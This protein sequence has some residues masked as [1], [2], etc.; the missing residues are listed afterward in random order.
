MRP[1]KDEIDDIKSLML[2]R[3]IAANPSNRIKIPDNIRLRKQSP[4]QQRPVSPTEFINGRDFINDRKNK[5]WSSLRHDMEIIFSGTDNDGNLIYSP[6]CNVYLN[7]SG[8]GSGKSTQ[9]ALFIS[10]MVYWLHCLKNPF[11]YFG[12]YDASTLLLMNVAPVEKKAKDIV[13][14]KVFSMIKNISW[15]RD[16]GYM[17]DKRLTSRLRF[18]RDRYD[19]NDMTREEVEKASPLI[20]IVPAS[21]KPGSAVGEDLFG[22]AIDEACSD[23]GFELLDGT[24]RCEEIFDAMHERR[25]SRFLDQGIIMMISS[26]GSEGRFMERFLT[27]VEEYRQIHDI[28][29][30]VAN[31][32]DMKI[33]HRRRAS[34]EANPKFHDMKTFHYTIERETNEGNILKYEL[35]IPIYFR[36]QMEKN[37]EKT[38]RNICAIPSVSS[39]PYFVEWDRIKDN[40]NKSRQDPMPDNGDDNQL[41]PLCKKCL[42][43]PYEK[44]TACCWELLPKSF[45]G[46]QDIWYMCHVDL[47]TG[48]TK[49]SKRCA[50]GLAISHR[51]PDIDVNGV[52]LPTVVIDLSVRFK[53]SAKKTIIK[54]QSGGSIT[55]VKK[56]EEIDISAV[57]DFIIKLDK[58]RGFKF[59]KIT[60]DGFQCVSEGTLIPT[61][62]G[63]LPIEEVKVG[64]L[65]QSRSGTKPVTKT[66]SFGK[67]PTLILKTQHNDILEGTYKH[68]IEVL[69]K[70]KYKNKKRLPVWEW[71]KIGDIKKGNVIRVWNRNS[72][73]S[74]PPF[75]FKYFDPYEL[76]K[77]SSGRLSKIDSW[78]FPTEMSIELAEWLGVIW[79][80]G[81]IRKDGVEV[82]TS[83]KEVSET[84]LVFEKLFGVPFR[85]KFKAPNTGTVI[86]YS[87]WLIGWMERNNLKKPLIPKAI[88]HSSKETQAAFLRG[89]FSADGSVSKRDGQASF[90]TVHYKLAQQVKIILMSNWGLS[91]TISVV[92]HDDK[93]YLHHDIIKSNYEEHYTLRIR[94]S[95]RKFY[96]IIGFL[97]KEKNDRMIKNI[98]VPGRFIFSKIKSIESGES[99]VYD[100]EIKDDPSYVANGFVSHNSRETL[101]VLLDQGYLAE[102]ASCTKDSY[103]TMRTLWYDSRVNIYQDNWLLS[104]MKKLEERNG[105]VVHAVGASDDLAQAVARVCEMAIENE[106]PHVQKQ[107]GRPRIG[108]ALSAVSPVGNFQSGRP[109]PTLTGN[110]SYL[111]FFK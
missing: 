70:W 79:G 62:R 2:Q 65:V 102:R 83:I 41:A 61:N 11:D 38:L 96:D 19:P 30:E 84:C 46:E 81:H 15:F 42:G 103:D 39:H 51:G 106:T 105:V 54:K 5:I 22:G 89:L 33:I 16:M 66:W 90:S 69:S 50:A 110:R 111:P 3:A 24:D 78:D 104:E 10:Y 36:E 55:T 97:Y 31:I 18:F 26:A 60:Y 99:E 91:S 63:I 67:Q 73:L 88:M 37:P 25:K 44:L 27:E 72:N 74:S 49:S 77:R 35:D 34:Y 95:R 75:K 43:K 32:G 57:R 108:A 4:W 9:V 101:Q 80:D 14:S 100:L 17:P 28:K 109:R 98:N 71:R 47:G 58:E 86:V 68:R 7:C 93:Y 13:F 64:D 59:A 6:I 85:V 53:A 76:G 82:T 87:K 92:K 107:R 94:G 56:T 40:V 23:G 8:L 1:L 20:A 12:L 48:G 45:R 21:G 52:L 29:T